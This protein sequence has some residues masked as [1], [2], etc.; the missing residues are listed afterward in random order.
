MV[1]ES[2]LGSEVL[3]LE[4]VI[5]EIDREDVSELHEL[6]Y[7]K[8]GFSNFDMTVDGPIDGA[9]SVYNNKKD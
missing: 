6:I 3:T 7:K 9:I 1:Y 5:R 4:P 8:E 2:I